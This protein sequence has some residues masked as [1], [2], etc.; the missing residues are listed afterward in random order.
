[1]HRYRVRTAFG[2]AQQQ[3]RSTAQITCGVCDEGAKLC[4]NAKK[5]GKTGLFSNSTSQSD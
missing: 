5:P 3:T 2:S 1:M 4:I